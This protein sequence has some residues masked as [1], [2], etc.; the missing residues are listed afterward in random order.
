MNCIN[1]R[2]VTG[3][4]QAHPVSAWEGVH[5]QKRIL[6][7]LTAKYCR[8]LLSLW[9]EKLAEIVKPL[10]QSSPD[11]KLQLLVFKDSIML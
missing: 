11:L 4:I 9:L 5:V 7:S 10:C 3:T 1:T 6:S 8:I 2:D